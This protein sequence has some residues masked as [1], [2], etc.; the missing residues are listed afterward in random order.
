MGCSSVE[1]PAM[2]P[3]RFSFLI[4]SIYAAVNELEDMFPGRHFTPDGHMVGSIGEALASHHYGITLHP[5]SHQVHDGHINGKQVQIKATQ[6]KRIAISSQPDYLLVLRINSDGTFA[7][8][9]NGPGRPVWQMVGHKPMPKNGQHQ[10]S[11]LAL[12]AI[13]LGVSSDDRIPVSRLHPMVD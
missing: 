6:G 13:Q 7:E 8:A 1:A 9:Y 11:L 10:I 4:R 2:K 3:E 12:A 5:S